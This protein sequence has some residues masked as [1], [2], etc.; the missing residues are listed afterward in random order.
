MSTLNEA[1]TRAKLIDPKIKVSGWGES[2]IEREHFFTKGKSITAGRIYLVGEES[3]RREA[4]RVD[5]YSA[6]AVR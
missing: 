3:R 5:Y 2:H 1:E 4:K 6:I